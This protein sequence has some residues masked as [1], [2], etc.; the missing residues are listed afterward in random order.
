MTKYLLNINLIKIPIVKLLSGPPHRP[1]TMVRFFNKK[2]FSSLRH[3]FAK[4][5]LTFVGFFV[6]Y[7]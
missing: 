3:I 1:Q 2:Y 4:K 5:T 7:K 6:L